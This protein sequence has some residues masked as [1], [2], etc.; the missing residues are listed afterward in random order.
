MDAKQH[1]VI[2][3]Q[4]ADIVAGMDPRMT[5]F[6][7]GATGFGPYNSQQA[8]TW[9]AYTSAATVLHVIADG[10]EKAASQE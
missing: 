7:Q 9:D 5:A 6:G 8:A 4:A 3:R 10:Y 2:W 1:A